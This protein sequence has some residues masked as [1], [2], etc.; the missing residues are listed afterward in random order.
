M[1]V[2]NL[3]YDSLS[4]VVSHIV[5]GSKASRQIS[6]SN[7]QE[8]KRLLNSSGLFGSTTSFYPP[9]SGSVDYIEFTVIA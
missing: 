1:A 8:A 3:S 7:E 9:A 2:S 4:K 6:D 5:N